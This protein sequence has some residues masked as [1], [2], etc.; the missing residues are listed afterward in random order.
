MVGSTAAEKTEAGVTFGL[1]K[2]EAVCGTRT[3][4]ALLVGSLPASWPGAGYSCLG[5]R[6]PSDQALS[7]QQGGFIPAPRQVGSEENAERWSQG[8]Q[9]HAASPSL[10]GPSEQ[11]WERQT[12]TPALRE[13]SKGGLRPAAD[14]CC[15]MCPP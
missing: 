15:D 7:L 1:W 4:L 14:P 5:S 6:E 2:A 12:L 3:D 9:L 11:R 8:E 10:Q 13:V